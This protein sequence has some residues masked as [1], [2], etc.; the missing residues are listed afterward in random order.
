ME[1]VLYTIKEVNAVCGCAVFTAAAICTPS[2]YHMVQDIWSR[3]AE[4]TDVLFS[5]DKT[6]PMKGE[7]FSLIVCL[8]ASCI[9][10]NPQH[11]LMYSPILLQA[12]F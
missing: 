11:C 10:V 5:A 12:H 3:L 4:H 1:N 7:E 8:M 9:I 6:V 2:S